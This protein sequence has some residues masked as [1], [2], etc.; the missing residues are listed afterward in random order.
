MD[1][2]VQKTPIFNKPFS[3]F[4]LAIEIETAVANAFEAYGLINR[5]EKVR[6][7]IKAQKEELERLKKLES[8]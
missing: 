4:Q 5:A 6:E 8:S 1:N 3:G 2:N 7:N